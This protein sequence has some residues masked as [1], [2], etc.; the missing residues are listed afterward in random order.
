MSVHVLTDG[1]LNFEGPWNQTLYTQSC[2]HS[3]NRR[4]IVSKAPTAPPMPRTS[5]KAVFIREIDER[6][7]LAYIIE[8]LFDHETDLIPFEVVEYCEQINDA[9]E[10]DAGKLW[11]DDLRVHLYQN[12]GLI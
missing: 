7:T 8:L 3:R 9:Q 10:L 2:I 5:Y 1:K 4:R 12:R 11:R 6:L